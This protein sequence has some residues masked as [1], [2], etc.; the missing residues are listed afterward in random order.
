MIPKSD[1]KG[2]SFVA[3]KPCISLISDWVYWSVAGRNASAR[4]GSS[5]L[6]VPVKTR[7]QCRRQGGTLLHFGADLSKLNHGRHEGYHGV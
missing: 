3:K 1:K 7:I 5:R 2:T 6:Y 4:H